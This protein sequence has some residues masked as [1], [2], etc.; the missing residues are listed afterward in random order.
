MLQSMG[1]QRAGHD[2]ATEQQYI[3]INLTESLGWT[4]ETNTILYI[5][6]T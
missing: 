4:P 6:Y 3:Y 2:L 1:S 5:N